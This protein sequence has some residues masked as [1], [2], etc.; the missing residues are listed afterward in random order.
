MEADSRRQMQDEWSESLAL[1]AYPAQA[2]YNNLK[3]R[4]LP[5]AAIQIDFVPLEA[6][7]SLFYIFR[8]G[9]SFDKWRLQEFASLT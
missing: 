9:F 8:F 2:L 7:Q 3:A 1:H 5:V 4:Q 6:F